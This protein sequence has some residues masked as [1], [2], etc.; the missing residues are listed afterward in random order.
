MEDLTNKFVSKYVDRV[1]LIYNPMDNRAIEFRPNSDYSGCTHPCRN[2]YLF[3]I[4]EDLFPNNTCI[5]VDYYRNI[6]YT[7]LQL[8]REYILQQKSLPCQFEVPMLNTGS[9]IAPNNTKNAMTSLQSNNIHF[10]I[11]INAIG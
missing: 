6:E 3:V 5:R 10:S 4:I 9:Q 8:Y 11:K 1:K 2:H 7:T